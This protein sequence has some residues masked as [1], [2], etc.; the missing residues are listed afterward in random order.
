MA[1]GAA[2]W[3]SQQLLTAFESRFN[4]LDPLNTLIPT[5]AK[6]ISPRKSE[7]VCLLQDM[8]LVFFDFLTTS[9]FMLD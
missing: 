4:F 8:S 2:S 9:H 6:N 1:H 5:K 3:F 7:T